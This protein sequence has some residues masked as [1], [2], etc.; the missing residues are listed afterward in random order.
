[1]EE[2]FD[3]EIPEDGIR[4]RSGK[5]SKDPQFDMNDFQRGLQDIEEVSESNLTVTTAQSNMS[6]LSFNISA[7]SFNLTSNATARNLR[8]L[9][10]P[11]FK[12][13]RRHMT[14][15]GTSKR[16]RNRINSDVMGNEFTLEPYQDVGDNTE[17]VSQKTDLGMFKQRKRRS[18]DNVV[19]SSK[20]PLG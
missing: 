16:K 17:E 3:S 10:S 9:P 19:G 5:K 8:E 12:P 6:A 18:S 11:A 14:D 7:S 4:N 20:P 15:S 13:N 1:M 2:I